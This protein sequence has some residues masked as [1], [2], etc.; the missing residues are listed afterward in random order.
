MGGGLAPPRV[1]LIL[2]KLACPLRAV[3]YTYLFPLS[4]QW[5]PIRFRIYSSSSQC[6]PQH[7]LHTT[8]CFGKCCPSFTYNLATCQNPSSKYCDFNDFF[9]L[10]YVATLALLFRT[11]LFFP[12]QVAR[13]RKTKQKKT[14]VG[15]SVGIVSPLLGS[16]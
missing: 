15:R 9:P 14:V 6:A 2:V 11:L 7:V 1:A 8:T 13:I 10:I 12:R 5:V 16:Q 4:S 3:T